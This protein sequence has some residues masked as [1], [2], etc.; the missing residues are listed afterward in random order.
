MPAR[1][2]EPV[3]PPPVRPGTHDEDREVGPLRGRRDD[4]VDVLVREEAGDAQEEVV[5]L[6]RASDRAPVERRGPLDVAGGKERRRGRD[7]LRVDAVGHPDRLARH[8]GVREVRVGAVRG[9]VVPAAQRGRG[10]PEHPRRHPPGGPLPDRL[11]GPPRPEVP[12]ALVEPARRRVAVHDL[13][14]RGGEAVGPAGRAREHHV[15]IDDL[16]GDR[17]GEE[18]QRKPVV[19][20]QGTEPVEGGGAH[21]ERGHLGEGPARVEER[22]VQGRAREGVGQK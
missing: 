3:E 1:R 8:R 11:A 14:P 4:G 16:S 12:V 15:R 17:P 20:A 2:D 18:R 6:D 5:A 9:V 21:V 7:H 19:A 22:R 10:D 13:A